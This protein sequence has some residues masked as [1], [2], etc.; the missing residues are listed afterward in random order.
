MWLTL[1]ENAIRRKLRELAEGQRPMVIETQGPS[2]SR[3]RGYFQRDVPEEDKE[4]THVGPGTPCGE[5]LRQYWQAIAVSSEIKDLP[6]AI[7]LLGEDLVLFRD[8]GG[9]VGLLHRHCSHRLA[10]LEYGI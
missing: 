4:L 7:R 10:S 1:W 8:L 2:M 3:Y 5:Y 6:K 9:R